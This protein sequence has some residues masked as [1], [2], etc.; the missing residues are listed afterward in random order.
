VLR[1]DGYGGAPLRGYIVE[2]LCPPFG[3]RPPHVMQLGSVGIEHLLHGAMPG[4][5]ELR[6]EGVQLVERS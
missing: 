2:L 5:N 6:D 3:A 1:I 4:A